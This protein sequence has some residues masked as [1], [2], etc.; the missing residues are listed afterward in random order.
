MLSCWTCLAHSIGQ[1]P[2]VTEDEHKKTLRSVLKVS[3]QDLWAAVQQH[4]RRTQLP[5]SGGEEAAAN[6]F[7]PGPRIIWEERRQG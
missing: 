3:D 4:W 1:G 7:P 6:E 2:T 5:P